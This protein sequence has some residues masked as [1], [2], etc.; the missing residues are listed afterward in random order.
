MQPNGVNHRYFK[1]RLSNLTEK[2]PILGLIHK[3]DKFFFGF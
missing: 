2:I 3:N 1:L